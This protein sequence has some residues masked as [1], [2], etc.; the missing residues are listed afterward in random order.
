MYVCYAML[1]S[2][3]SSKVYLRR[4]FILKIKVL[5][6]CAFE[7]NMNLQRNTSYTV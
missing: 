6:S 5:I 3:I 2:F 1:L 7:Y 4:R